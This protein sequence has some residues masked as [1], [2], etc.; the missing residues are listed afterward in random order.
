MIRILF[1][2]ALTLYFGWMVLI[3]IFS[4]EIESMRSSTVYALSS[5]PFSFYLHLSFRGF[6][7]LLLIVAL[8]ISI[9]FKEK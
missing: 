2:F 4:G 7:F 3:A 8:V 1:F 5:E 6:M 9:K